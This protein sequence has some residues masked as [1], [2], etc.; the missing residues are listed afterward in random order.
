M[1]ENNQ[2]Y[3]YN[4]AESKMEERKNSKVYSIENLC[5]FLIYAMSTFIKQSEGERSN[6]DKH[7]LNDAS[8]FE[9]GCYFYFRIDLWLFGNKP[10]LREKIGTM[11]SSIIYQ[12][13]SR[14]LSIDGPNICEIFKERINKYAELIKKGDVVDS[15][16]PYLLD[17]VLHTKD[18]ALPKKY[19]SGEVPLILE[20]FADEALLKI[21]IMS[22]EIHMW[23]GVIKSLAEYCNSLERSTS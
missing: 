11:F 7:Y 20:S 9:F 2:S 15:H 1:N 22:W 21:K 12:L 4:W 5:L 23:P 6:V 14:A 13:F 18:G 17:L 8:L 16:Y 10:N 19:N 3:V